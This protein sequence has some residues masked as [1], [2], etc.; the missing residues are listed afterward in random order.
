MNI[1]DIE[2]RMILLQTII[3]SLASIC[4]IIPGI[5]GQFFEYGVKNRGVRRPRAYCPALYYC[6][7]SQ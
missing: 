6:H 2:M 1:S 7:T 5:Y 3:E 4:D